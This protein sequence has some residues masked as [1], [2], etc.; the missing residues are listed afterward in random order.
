MAAPPS[1]TGV[2]EK[3]K[4]RWFPGDKA[5]LAAV[6]VLIYRL[7][8]TMELFSSRGMVLRNIPWLFR[9]CGAGLVILAILA[10]PGEVMVRVMMVMM[11]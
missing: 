6:D 8:E 7:N 9:V 1:E 5:Y 10:G 3:K 11:I 2:R 4:R